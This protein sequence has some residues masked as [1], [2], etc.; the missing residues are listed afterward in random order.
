[1]AN[2]VINK[3]TNPETITL[4]WDDGTSTTIYRAVYE[5]R[6]AVVIQGKAQ[7][8][9]MQNVYGHYVDEGHRIP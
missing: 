5:A 8:E 1:M 3:G 9:E 4:N 6:T 7:A 2:T